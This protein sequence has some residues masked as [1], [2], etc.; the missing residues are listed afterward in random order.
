MVA[1]TGQLPSPVRDAIR[2]TVVSFPQYNCAL[3][4]SHQHF[5]IYAELHQVFDKSQL[6][7]PVWGMII[8]SELSYKLF[9]MLYK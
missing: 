7:P 8:I 5:L 6:V 9:K 1:D 4:L 2:R 3:T